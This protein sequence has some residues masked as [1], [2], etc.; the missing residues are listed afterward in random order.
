MRTA[1][2]HQA[3]MTALTVNK[4]DPK[5]LQDFLALKFA[6]SRRTAKAVVDGRSVWVNRKCIWMARHTLK[7]G[8]LIEIPTQVVKGALKQGGSDSSGKVAAQSVASKRHV[9]VLWSDESYLVCDKPSGM[10]SSQEPGSAEHILRVQENI[11]T[12]VAVHR[13]D[14]DTTGCLL[15]A[16]NH[17]AFEAAVEKFKV[18]GVKKLYS[19][20]VAG[21]FKH[22]RQT[23]DAELDGQA[24]VSKVIREAVGDE[25]SFL[26]VV[27]ETGRTN[28]IRRH[29]ASI[30]HPIVG[31]RT[32]GL[33]NARD[34]RL[35]RVARQ[36][37]HASTLELPHPLK[38]KE[39]IKVH[40]PLPADFRAALKL[41]D[42]GK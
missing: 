37:L 1:P 17:A 16:K 23:I 20:V 42:M 28:Q 5:V 18:H 33:K 14:R 2:Q 34:P 4:P 7:T 15:F 41:F 8:D 38:L 31:D 11:P 40:S 22:V 25:A 35:M 3:G 32:F 26:K 29:L 39:S 6:L 12:L 10:I 36:M 27:I 21:R 19:A 30:R 13:L 24:A 9:R